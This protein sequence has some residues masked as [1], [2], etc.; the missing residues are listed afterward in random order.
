[1]KPYVIWTPGYVTYYGGIVVLHRLCHEINRLGGRA[2]LFLASPGVNPRWDTPIWDGHSFGDSI[3]VYPEIVKDNPLKATKIVRWLLA[4]GEV[5]GDG[6]TI[7]FSRAISTE[8]D[9]FHLNVLDET[10][11]HPN[12]EGPS[13]RL[14]RIYEP[15]WLGKAEYWGSKIRDED[16]GKTLITRQWPSSQFGLADLF[17][18]SRLL[19]SYDT[20]SSV[21]TEAAM[22]GCPVLIIPNGPYSREEIARGEMGMDGIAWGEEELP[23]AIATL[24]DVMVSYQKVASGRS[25]AV[26]DFIERTQSRF[27]R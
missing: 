4:K 14:G 11:W 12:S 21:N 9:V 25:K 13:R 26:A 27:P 20:L 19:V 17:R 18:R 10:I 2:S 3:V 1:M 5:P 16:F 8:H 22:C 15:V 7:S 6:Y 23:R 24:P